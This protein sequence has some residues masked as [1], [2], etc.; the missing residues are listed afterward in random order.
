MCK[1]VLPTRY[2][3]LGPE[4]IPM[5]RQSSPGDRMSLLSARPAF[6]LRKRLPDGASPNS[7][8]RHLITAYYWSINPEGMKGCI[9][10]EFMVMEH[11]SAVGFHHSASAIWNSLPETT[12][13]SQSL[14]NSMPIDT[15]NSPFWSGPHYRTAMTW[16]VVTASE[17]ISLQW[18]KSDYYYYYYYYQL[19]L[20][21]LLLMLL[22]LQ[23]PVLLLSL[24][25]IWRC[26]RR[27]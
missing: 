12:I 9:K 15:Q 10:L 13:Y 21:L 26:R 19:V 3:A 18:E 14:T 1:K 6:Y 5:Y 4:L 16:R 2:L 20:L 25:H 7:G 23:L 11:S 22:L 17:V 27:G 24:I 8:N